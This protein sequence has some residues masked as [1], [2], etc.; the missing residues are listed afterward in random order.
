MLKFIKT[1]PNLPERNP[2]FIDFQDEVIQMYVMSEGEEEGAEKQGR[3]YLRRSFKRRQG[4]N[5][6][7]S[8]SRVRQDVNLAIYI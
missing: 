4:G 5:Q 3:R 8:M 6:T 7:S 2:P 1:R